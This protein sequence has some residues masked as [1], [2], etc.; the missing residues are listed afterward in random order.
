[1]ARLIIIHYHLNPGGVTRIIES[2]IASLVASLPDRPIRV[3][4]GSA[5][6]PEAIT[7][8]GAE[9]ITDELLNYLTE[10]INNIEIRYDQTET[11]LRRH[12]EPGDIIHFH[13]MNLGKNPLLTLAVSKLAEEG[14]RVVNH[15]HDFSEDRPKNQEYLKSII[16]KKFG[17]DLKATMYPRL[18]NIAYITLST[19]DRERLIGY[20]AEPA[21]VFLVPNPVT[22]SA[23]VKDSRETL[24][25]KIESQLQIPHGKK[26]ITYPVRVIRRK[27]IGEYILLCTLFSDSFHWMVTQP[28][29]NPVELKPYEVWK[30]IC[31]EQGIPLIFE[32]GVRCS[33]EELLAASD[34][35]F[36]TSIQEGFGMAY[37]EPWLLG[38]PVGGRN[39]TNI[40]TDLRK[41]GLRF[42]LLYD[43][44][45]VPVENEQT[46]FAKLDMQQQM[47]II[48]N[49]GK[50]PGL[51]ESIRK[52]NP[53]LEMLDQEIDEYLIHYN[54][55]IIRTD[56]S[57]STYAK[58]LER[59]YQKIAG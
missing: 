51:R 12:I 14:Y 58:R 27:N 38:T 45:L 49:A 29:K 19:S 3:L 57:L 24:K 44:L 16:V 25:L 10:P 54:Q 53:A 34:W 20:G 7:G 32:A 50:D 52:A 31:R 56:Y 9:L 11:F 1:M 13:N 37:L 41:S 59:I 33:F 48:R 5:T 40:T 17:R 46:D 21:L 15:A 35:C 36:T 6:N 18:S 4:C 55:H 22:F 47:T 43:E 23:N 8:Q 42:P 30:A 39:L 26:I 2:Q 28:P